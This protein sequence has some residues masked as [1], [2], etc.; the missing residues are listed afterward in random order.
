MAVK[1]ILL[2]LFLIMIL[3]FVACGGGAVVDE[4]ED[5]E[6][7]TQEEDETQ[8]PQVEEVEEG[9]GTPAQSCATPL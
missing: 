3:S 1:R 4:G 9:Q 7:I 5:G 2:S 6:V 8:A